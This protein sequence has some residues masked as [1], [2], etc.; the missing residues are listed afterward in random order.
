MSTPVT[1]FIIFTF[2]NHSSSPTQPPAAWSDV[3]STLKS[4]PGVNALYTGAQLEDP[5]KT[6]LVIEW[7][8][9]EAFSA[10]ASSESY[11][12]WFASLKAVVSA[13]PVFYKVPF[14]ADPGSDPASVL[15]APCTEVFVAYGVEPSFAGKTA[16]FARGLTEGRAEVAGFHG[17]AYGNISTPLAVDAPDGDGEKGPAVTLV[18]GWDSKQAHLDAKAK[19]GP[20]SDNI[21]LLRSGRKDISMYHVNFKKI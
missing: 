5:S 12:P 15:R 18:L 4:V 11:M 17:H 3:V 6:V 21:H 2:K 13:S 8:S 10:F 7:A 20:I 1:E 14:T 19:A 9:P 16:E